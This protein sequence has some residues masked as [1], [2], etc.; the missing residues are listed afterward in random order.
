MGT[1]GPQV[2]SRAGF[3]RRGPGTTGPMVAPEQHIGTDTRSAQASLLD[4][5]KVVARVAIPTIMK[6]VIKR[7]PWFVAIAGKVQPD[8]AAVKLLGKLRRKYGEVL[9]RLRTPGRQFAVPLSAADV[10]QLLT[11]SPHPFSPATVEKK[12]AL[13]HFQ[14]HGVLISEG[15]RRADR[16]QLNEF[17]LERGRPLHDLAEPWSKV[18]H[19]E[20][21]RML[22][23]AH[24][25]LD[26][27]TFNRHW[28]N[29]V[30]QV[31]FGGDASADREVTD[32][33]TRLRMDANWA[34]AH[35]RRQRTYT[36]FLTRLNAQLALER[37]DSLA[38]RLA[39]AHADPGVDP[40]G[41][42]PH[43]LFAFDAA[44]IAAFRTLAL[45][46]THR[47]AAERARDESGD[48][49]LPYLRACVLESVRLWPTTP[50]LLRENTVDN[51]WGPT[52]TTF[53]IFTPFFHRDP[54][55]LTYADTFAPD[56]WLDGR[57]QQNPALVPFSAGPAV[58]PGQ[59]LVQFTT[60]TLLANLLRERH[61]DLRGTRLSPGRLPATLNN[62]GLRF[63]V[64]PV[65]Q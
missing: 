52:G 36:Q 60:S 24:G 56:I 4:T 41:Q 65:G 14:P 30:R 63:A 11:G 49:V 34:Y 2:I 39:D 50:A 20:A 19:A 55:H 61:F 27:D 22:V 46:A 29:I 32:L 8:R 31:V 21:Q 51:G 28:W 64:S 10:G 33:L 43:W 12:A 38:S 23:A 17:V 57:A 58:C 18:I 54:D 44:G 42:V 47:T 16:R 5:G 48:P 62:F 15:E 59:D 13:S 1:A 9:L 7:R 6:G 40:V 25:S 37:P 3:R 45:L 35:P 53:F 26:W